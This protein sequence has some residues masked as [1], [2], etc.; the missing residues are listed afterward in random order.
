[1]FLLRQAAFSRP[2]CH[3]IIIHATTTA[4]D[5]VHVDVHMPYRISAYSATDSAFRLKVEAT[6]ILTEN[7]PKHKTLA[8]LASPSVALRCMSRSTMQRINLRIL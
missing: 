3:C 1:M 6:G 4:H 5:I 8:T 2:K 7:Y